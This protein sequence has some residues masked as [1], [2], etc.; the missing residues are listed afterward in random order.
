MYIRP[1][2]SSDY[3]AIA[4][5]NTLAFKR[6]NEAQLVEKI[7]KSDLY[8]SQLSLVAELD[9][10]VIAHIMFSH[11][12]LVDDKTKQ[13]LLLAP[14]AVKP[15]WQNRGI[16]SKLVK[17]GL[18]AAEAKQEPL[19]LVLGHSNFYSRFGFMPSKHYQIEPPFPVPE[20]V[21]MVKPLKSYQQNYKGK[22]VLPLAFKEV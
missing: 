4:K 17:I 6:D 12:D 14:L 1:E 21:F 10:T 19:I 3:Q 2:Q 11:V 13:V 20:E 18:E 22:V 9:G 15:E 8:I 7:R 5:V 16:G